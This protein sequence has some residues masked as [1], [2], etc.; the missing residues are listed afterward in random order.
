MQRLKQNSLTSILLLI[1]LIVVGFFYRLY[2]LNDNYSFWTD[3]NHIAIF[4][5]AILERGEPVLVNGYSTGIYQWLQY[6]L[7]AISAKIFGLNEFAIRFPSVIF[8]VLTIWAVYLVGKELFNKNIGLVAAA[9][10]TFLNIEILWSRQARPYQALQFFY[11]LS[12]WFIYKLAKEKRFNWRYFGGFLGSGVLASLMHGLGLVIFFNG[13]LYLFLFRFSWFKKWWRAAGVLA[14]LPLVWY[15]WDYISAILFRLG[16]TNN[17]FY[18]RVFL[19]HNYPLLVFLALIGFLVNV[20]AKKNNWQ[21]PVLFLLTQ[22]FIASFLLGQPF[23][24]YLYIVFP[25]LVLFSSVGLVEVSRWLKV[26]FLPNFLIL[27]FLAFFIIALGNKFTLFPQKTYSL[28]ADMQEIPEVDY[29]RIYSFIKEKL[30]AN[31]EAVFISNWND[32]AVWY[33]GE[34]RLDYILRIN[35][36]GYSQEPLSGARYLSNL[37]DFQKVMKE[38]GGGFVL[39]ESWESELPAGT[40]EYIQTHL[41][42]ELEVDRLYPVQPRY[43]PVEVYSWGFE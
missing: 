7:S 36:K 28:N 4:A 8:G 21:L 17:L 41:K 22:G 32:H 14:V 20:F 33:L 40:R 10:T 27:L 12:A 39:L 16:E 23:T 30:Q 1:I 2:G 29:K 18:Y 25:F 3:E 11:L 42:K 38:S 24:R 34:G 19:W 5:R 37:Y 31:P 26:S 15:L 35:P 9:F 43:W 13:F 6:W